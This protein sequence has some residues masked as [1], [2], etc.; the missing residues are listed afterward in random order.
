MALRQSHM[1]PVQGF[2]FVGI[3]QP[4]HHHGNFVGPGRPRRF[5]QSFSRDIAPGVTAGNKGRRPH[6]VRQIRK[7]RGIDMAAAAALIPDFLCHMADEHHIRGTQGQYPILIFQ[8]HRALLGSF[9]RQRVVGIPVHGRSLCLLGV[10]HQ[11]ENPLYR[12]VDI[13]FGKHPVFHR[14]HCRLL[15]IVR[16][17][18]HI[19]ITACLK[20]LDPVVHGAPVGDHHAGKAPICTENIRQQ[21]LA[22]AAML[23]VD[24]IVGAHHRFRSAFFYGNFKGGKIDF[25]QGSPVHP[26]VAVHPLILLTV[27]GKMLQA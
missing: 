1:L 9:P 26:A 5:L 27:G 21:L 2:G 3:R 6:G 20:P 13:R 14:F 7:L 8:Q 10:L 23:A 4:R 19:Q 11:P 25:P 18:G 17:A 22:V 12:C 24:F 15:H 16:A